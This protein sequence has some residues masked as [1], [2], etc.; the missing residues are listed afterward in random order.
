MDQRLRPADRASLGPLR[1]AD[2]R[3]IAVEGLWDLEPGTAANGGTD[4]V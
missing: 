4:A 2:G 3:A 1:G